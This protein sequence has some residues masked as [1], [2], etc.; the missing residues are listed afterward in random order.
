MLTAFAAYL[1]THLLAYALLL[2]HSPRLRTEKGIL[3]Y[4]LASATL[5]GLAALVLVLAEPV[6]YRL[7]ELFLILSVHGIYSISFLELWSLAQ[8]GYSLSILRSVARAEAGGLEAEFLHLQEIGETKQRERIMG[9][10]E[11]GLIARSDDTIALTSRGRR[12]ARFLHCLFKWID[13]EKG[14]SEAA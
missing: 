3:L 13:S 11:L 14:G 5:I 4:H 2:R 9:L 12:V 6:P 7:P 8:G 1:L 10:Q